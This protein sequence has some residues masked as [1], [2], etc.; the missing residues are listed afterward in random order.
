MIWLTIPCPVKASVRTPT[1]KPIMA[2]RPLKS[3]ARSRF[4]ALRL[5]PASSAASRRAFCSAAL[6]ARG[7]L[8]AAAGEARD[9]L[10]AL[11]ARPRPGRPVHTEEEKAAANQRRSEG[12]TRRRHAASA[13]KRDAKAQELAARPCGCGPLACPADGGKEALH[14]AAAEMDAASAAFNTARNRKN[15][16]ETQLE[17]ATKNNGRGD[18][19]DVVVTVYGDSF[20]A[21]DCSLEAVYRHGEI[22]KQKWIM[23]VF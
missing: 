7:R 10:A 6:G 21:V 16:A 2:T 8:E 3:S 20:A 19:V 4:R 13:A 9:R 18:A 1:T 12:Q 22:G 23:K 17:H 15:R 14:A 11:E 5:T